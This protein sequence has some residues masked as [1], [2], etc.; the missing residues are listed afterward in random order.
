[1]QSAGKELV[2]SDRV[3]LFLKDPDEDELYATVFS[4]GTGES[5]T[6]ERVGHTSVANYVAQLKQCVSYKGKLLK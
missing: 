4:V 5:D 1:M 3:S 2:S 6:V